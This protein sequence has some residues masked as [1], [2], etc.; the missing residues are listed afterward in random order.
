MLGSKAQGVVLSLRAQTAADIAHAL[1]SM[2]F[3]ETRSAS[4][5]IRHQAKV[6]TKR[7]S[8]CG[9]LLLPLSAAFL[10]LRHFSLV[11]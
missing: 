8:W 2:C 1:S 5:E 7:P 9:P 11:V 4:S 6:L 3:A 10:V